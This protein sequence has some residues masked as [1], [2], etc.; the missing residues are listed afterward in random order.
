MEERR[1]KFRKRLKERP[2]TKR[3]AGR[4]KGNKRDM[5]KKAL[6]GVGEKKD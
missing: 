2:F 1:K 6:E 4:V 5:V 3:A